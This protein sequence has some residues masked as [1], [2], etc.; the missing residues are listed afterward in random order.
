[1][2]NPFKDVSLKR[3]RQQSTIIS[4]PVLQPNLTCQIRRQLFRSTSNWKAGCGFNPFLFNVSISR[5]E[6][7]AIGRLSPPSQPDQSHRR[8]SDDGPQHFTHGHS[9][10]TSQLAFNQ[11]RNTGGWRH[12]TEHCRVWRIRTIL[13]SYRGKMA[14]QVN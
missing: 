9:Q 4:G 8:R 1:M 3:D 13:R 6:E 5:P 2:N 10:E 14:I 11:R 7:G 12:I